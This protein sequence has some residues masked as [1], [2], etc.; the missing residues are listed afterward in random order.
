MAASGR[1]DGAGRVFESWAAAGLG[2]VWRN[3][4]TEEA[5]D[6]GSR[7]EQSAD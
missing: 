6:K 3:D 5:L 1:Y 4:A 2:C 7:N